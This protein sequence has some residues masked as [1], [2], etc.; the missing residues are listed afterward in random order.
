MGDNAFSSLSLASPCLPLHVNKAPVNPESFGRQLK[1]CPFISS[2]GVLIKYPHLVGNKIQSIMKTPGCWRVPATR[3]SHRDIIAAIVDARIL[4]GQ[5]WEPSFCVFFLHWANWLRCSHAT[6]DSLHS[7]IKPADNPN[8]EKCFLTWQNQT[9]SHSSHTSISPGWW[10]Q[11]RI[12]FFPHLFL[13]SEIRIN[14]RSLCRKRQAMP[15]AEDMFWLSA[16]MDEILY[17]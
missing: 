17:I 4:M 11:G 3:E 8:K 14:V 2:P 9:Q 5:G 7:T 10:H 16:V 13:V 1:C 15:T 6:V 12:S